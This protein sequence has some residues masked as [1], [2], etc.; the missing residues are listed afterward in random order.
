MRTN[1]LQAALA[2]SLEDLSE[3]TQEIN[4][5]TAETVIELDAVLEEVREA[6]DTVEGQV[7]L[8]LL[9]R[10]VLALRRAAQGLA[11]EQGD[12]GAELLLKVGVE[13]HAVVEDEAGGAVEALN[14]RALTFEI[15][16][17][18]CRE[19]V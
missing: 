2:V 3:T 15:G 18:S 1:I 10:R 6:G 16:R 8:Q 14:Q 19:R 12:A 13:Q 7:A 4:P 17:A 9:E 11:I 5:L